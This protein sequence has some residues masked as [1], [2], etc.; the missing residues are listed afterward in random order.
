MNIKLA[1]TNEFRH[2]QKKLM[3]RYG[4][5][6]EICD[7]MTSWSILKPVKANMMQRYPEFTTLW[8]GEKLADALK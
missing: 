3:N 8:T 4:D 2:Y 7:N 5:N 6:I 1:R